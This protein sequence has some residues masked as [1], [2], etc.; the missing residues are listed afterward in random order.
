MVSV[1]YWGSLYFNDMSEVLSK[2]FDTFPSPIEVLYISINVKYSVATALLG[3]PSPIGVLYISIKEVN[4][5]YGM[6]EAVS[7][8]YWGSLYFNERKNDNTYNR[9][10]CFRPL[11]GFFIFQLNH[12]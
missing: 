1:P 7:V 8:P 5:L 2:L 10:N 11:L 12:E 4:E 3:F 6:D 9:N